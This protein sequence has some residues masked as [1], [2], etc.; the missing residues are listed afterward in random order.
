MIRSRIMFQSHKIKS[1]VFLS[2]LTAVLITPVH[3]CSRDNAAITTADSWR[4]TLPES[5]RGL[6][7]IDNH[8]VGSSDHFVNF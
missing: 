5:I 8:G 6:S 2:L 4:K 7:G 3:G 1:A